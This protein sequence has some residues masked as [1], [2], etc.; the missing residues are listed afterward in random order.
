M[1]YLYSPLQMRTETQIYYLWSRYYDPEVGRFS[2]AD[3]FTS[4]GAGL[5]GNNM[6]AYCNNNPI[7]YVDPSGYTIVIDIEDATEYNRILSYLRRLSDD[8]II[9]VDNEL[10]IAS[11][12]DGSHPA[13]TQMLRELI[14]S[15]QTFTVKQDASGSPR[16]VPDAEY[17]E[18]KGRWE[19][20]PI[21][22]PVGGTVYLNSS[23]DKLINQS[24]TMIV[25]HELVHAWR[26]S[27]SCSLLMNSTQWMPQYNCIIEEV[28][29]VGLNPN[30][31]YSLYCEN[32]LRKEHGLIPRTAY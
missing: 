2:N 20:Q 1:K 17:V 14:S 28:Y 7:M 3:A 11:Y 25:G 18:N 5:L 27:N 10:R 23:D 8:I 31:Y 19:K 9:V 15:R 29:A 13:G 30:L 24:Q 6:Y 21:T 4:T 22:S 12:R 16:Y 32:V 26:F